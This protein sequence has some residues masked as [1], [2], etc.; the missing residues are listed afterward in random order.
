MDTV[1]EKKN[2]NH[3]HI[4]QQIKKMSMEFGDH[5]GQWIL[6]AGRVG[7]VHHRLSLATTL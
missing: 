1:A 2:P 4:A 5:V 7:S 6:Y 3:Y